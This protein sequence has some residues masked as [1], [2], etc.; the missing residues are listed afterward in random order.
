MATDL[1][2]TPAELKIREAAHEQA[3][4][5]AE[6]PAISESVPAEKRVETLAGA[7]VAQAKAVAPAEAVSMPAAQ[8]DLATVLDSSHVEVPPVK[9]SQEKIW[10][11]NLSA[12][13]EGKLDAAGEALISIRPD[14][15]PSGT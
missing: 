3:E 5:A 14:T 15:D 12:V 10:S 4:R 7:D 9:E 1:P 6:L 11:K 2:G 13:L 8:H